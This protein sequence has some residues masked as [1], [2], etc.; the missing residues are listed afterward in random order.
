MKSKAWET[1]RRKTIGPT[2]SEWQP[3]TPEDDKAILVGNWGVSIRFPLNGLYA[4]PGEL[5]DSNGHPNGAGREF[6][7]LEVFDF[8]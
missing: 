1:W 2:P 5:S 6:R 7:P 4:Y 3:V 8:G